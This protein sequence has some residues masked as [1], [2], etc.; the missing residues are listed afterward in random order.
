MYKKIFLLFICSFYSAQIQRVYYE[1]TYKPSITSDN[2]EK[3]IFYLDS[4]NNSTSIFRTR[5]K[6][7]SDSII[8]HSRDF[9]PN[10]NPY[11]LFNFRINKDI[12]KKSILFTDDL[13]LGDLSYRENISLLWNISSEV[14]NYEGHKIQKAEVKYGGRHWNAWFSEDFTINDGPYIFM[15]LPG[16]IVEI[17]DDEKNYHWKMVGLKKLNFNTINYLEDS[18][19]FNSVIVDKK[20]FIEN[21]N[22]IRSDPF[23]MMMRSLEN[24]NKDIDLH[25]KVREEANSIKEFYQKNNNVIE[26]E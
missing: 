22:M 4:D 24:V 6:Y 15:G 7:E 8:N 14:G 1:L 5:L 26:K 11:S 20:T 9:I 19:K 3:L 13:F 25:H 18:K 2:K 21:R 23:P 16:L 17:Y 10:K 12:Q